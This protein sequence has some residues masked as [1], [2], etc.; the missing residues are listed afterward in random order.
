[1][2]TRLGTALL[3]LIG[4]ATALGAPAAAQ[5]ARPGAE[6]W[7]L[8]TSDSAA[9]LYVYELGAG[10][11]V[12]VL[13]G[14]PGGEYSPM[15]RVASG[16]EDRFRWVFYD[17]RGSLRSPA[18][19]GAVSLARHVEDIETLRRALGVERIHL[20][21]HSFGTFVAM[22]Y[23]RAHPEHVGNLVLVGSMDPMNGAQR[24]TPE[25]LAVAEGRPAELERFARRP[26]VQAELEKAGADRPD[27]TPK[28]EANR[29]RIRYAA[30]NVVHVERWRELTGV[31]AF[32]RAAAGRATMA[33]IDWD[34]DFTPVLARH[35]FPITVIHGDHDFVVR[36]A[37]GSL[38]WKKAR[39]AGARNVEMV[40]IPGAGHLPWIDEPAA[41]RNAVRNALARR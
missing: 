41:F 4:V 14:G 1:M 15:L 25:E 21:A 36:P 35:P 39:A 32:W 22:H 3:L 37:Q 29:W 6:E 9:K 23:L 33:G 2:T 13:H 12:V 17:Q 28:E 38:A 20:L 24:F 11:P 5:V 16:L 10:E 26:E 8:T 18:D 40:V 34:F 30:S 7:F 19:S 27:R 31:P